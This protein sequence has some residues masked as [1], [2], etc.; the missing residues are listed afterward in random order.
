MK[1]EMNLGAWNQVFAIPSAVVDRHLKLA[2]SAQLKVLLWLLRHA[3]T[4]NDPETIGQ[5]L[6]LDRADVCDAMQYWITAGL[7]HEENGALTPPEPVAEAAT[8]VT[9]PAVPETIPTPVSAVE[10]EEVKKTPRRVTRPKQ[11][12]TLEIAERINNADEVRYMLD[13]AETIFA[14]PLTTPEMGTLVN[15]YDWDGLPCDVIIMIIQYAVNADKCNMS[16]IEK[17]AVSWAAE[18]IDTHEKAEEKV[19][20]LDERNQAWTR[21]SRLFGIDKRPPSAAEAEAVSRWLGEWHFSDEMIREAYDRCVDS[22][23]KIRFQYINKILERWNKQDIRTI[24]A[25]RADILEKKPAKPKKPAAETRDRSYDL[26]QFEEMA[27][28]GDALP[29]P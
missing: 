7:I 28:Y 9:A 5:A 21:I 20:R 24:E 12:N 18:G 16:Y 29:K 8:P 17:M 15:L 11:L 1:Y 14:R 3:G 6:G 2:G 4:Q 23:G 22:T 27:L 25:A 19:R 26:E 13:A 10:G